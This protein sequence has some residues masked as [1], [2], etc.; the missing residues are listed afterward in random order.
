M[1]HRA[2]ACMLALAAAL[3]L[4]GC[5]LNIAADQALRAGPEL[6]SGQAASI[7]RL[8]RASRANGDLASAVNFYNE[9]NTRTH[10]DD[11]ILVEYGNV[12]VDVGAADDAIDVFSKVAARSAVRVAALLGQERAHLALAQPD[13][14]LADVEQAT[15]LAPRDTRVLLGL[16]VV[17]DVLDRHRDAQA[18]YRAVLAQAPR[19]VGARNNLA[20]SLALTGQF[21]EAL[22]IITPMAKSLNATPKVRQNLALIY[23]LMGDRGRAE[24]LS[25]VD[26]DASATAA[27]LRLFE[28]LRAASG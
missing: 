8:A 18:Q 23:G 26:L 15:A 22:D 17:L 12:L 1:L 24:A 25:R 10:A 7:L 11:V 5:S 19:H 27:N 21:A 16:G 14:A 2:L 4:A 9:L 13:K 6:S 28:L 3:A 20:L